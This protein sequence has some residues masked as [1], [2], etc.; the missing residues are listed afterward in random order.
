M[1]NTLAIIVMVLMLVLFA[2]GQPVAFAM[3]TMGIVGLLALLGGKGL[4][5]IQ[6]ILWQSPNNAV[7]IAVPLFVLMGEILLHTGL[8]GR[9]YRSMAY[10]LGKV[11][12][13][14]FHSN[15]GACAIFAAIS[16]SSPATAAAI[17]AVSIPEMEKRN[18]D[19]NMMLGSL[20]AGGTL[21]ILIPPS[22]TLIVYGAMVGESI[23]QLFMAGFIPGIMLA[24]L[25]M[26]YIFIRS[27][28]NPKLA[29]ALESVS[30]RTR[31]ASLGMV[32]P[33]LL[34]IGAVLG[35]IYLG[36]ATPTEAA[37]LGV[38]MALILGFASRT[39]SWKVLRGSMSETVQV[40]V[41]VMVI[42]IGA[43][44]ISLIMS[45]V[46]IPIQIAEAVAESTLSPY[47]ILVLIYAIFLV[48]GCFFDPMSVMVLTIPVLYPVLL[49]LGFDLIWFGI[50]LV[51]L[52]EAGMITPPVGLNLYIIQSI[53]PKYRFEQ[54]V[55]GV[56]PFFLMQLVAIAIITLIPAIATWLPSTMN[57][58]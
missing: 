3:F 43:S 6:W 38:V 9:L 29:P 19:Q 52:I 34:L 36:V 49:E 39:L 25:F 24:L 53:A 30:W 54:I 8:S 15:I 31:F 41:S 11:P 14:L 48:L 28:I 5:S 40:T 27:L 46:G 57:R 44:L 35:T 45:Q 2:M 32:A 23:G 20:A 18:Y 37:A 10:W 51:I 4:I 33:I 16:G 21:G 58:G 1:D 22:I 26:I 13:G 7:L 55:S 50:I 17:G 47:V 12:G 42:F 56:M